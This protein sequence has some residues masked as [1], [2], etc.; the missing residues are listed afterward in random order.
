MITIGER[1]YEEV[2][3]FPVL[4]GGWEADSRGWVVNDKGKMR[5]VLTTHGTPYFAKQRELQGR[6]EEYRKATTATLH[7]LSLI[8]ATSK[9]EEKKVNK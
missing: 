5:I 6:I 9:P 8:G 3:T 1:L 7:A 4:W 2:Y